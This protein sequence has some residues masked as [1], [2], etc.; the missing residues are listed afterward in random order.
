MNTN[1]IG[2]LIG[3]IIPAVIFGVGGVFVKASN[4]QGISLSYYILF[5]SIGVL[6]FSLIAF[7]ILNGRVVNFKSGAFA[8]TVGATWVIGALLVAFAIIKYNTPMSI[9]S[10]LNCTACLYT[11]LLSLMI[12][13]EWK[14]THVIRLIIGSI[15]IVAGAMLVSTSINTNSEKQQSEVMENTVEKLP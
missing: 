13:S 1:V 9:I 11:I 7:F 5:T 10:A 15:L 12:F 6:L 4:Q 8:F 14:E 3:G 2:V